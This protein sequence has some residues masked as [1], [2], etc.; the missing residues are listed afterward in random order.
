MKPIL[1][2]FCPTTTVFID[3]NSSMLMDLI[4]ALNLEN[5]PHL[6]FVQPQEGLSFINQDTYRQEF[7]ER[8]IIEDESQE[9]DGV[10]FSPQCFVPELQSPSRYHQISVLVVDYEMPGMTGLDL[11]KQ[12]QNPYVKTILLTGVADESIAIDAFNAG[13]I[14]T[15]IR[16]HNPNFL[17]LLRQA[18]QTNQQAYFQ[19]LFHTPLETLKRRP[20][21]TALGD[22]AFIDYFNGLVTKHHIQEYYL[23]EGTG[24]FLMI[25]RKKKLH[26]LI[27]LSDEMIKV[28]LT[29][30]MMDTLTPGKEGAI[31]NKELIPCYQNPFTK[32]YFETDNLENY[33]HK[34]TLLKGDH[35]PFYTVFGEGLIQVTPKDIVFWDDVKESR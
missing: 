4:P 20:G 33:L 1:P 30:A 9:G 17:D 5:H 2:C 3:D 10:S 28:Y 8:M 23:M 22:S 27:T 6:T 31:E 19:E 11:C 24:S 16:K 32:E 13:L 34:P 18:I 15:Y 12:I 29:W 25:D 14:S 7:V 21:Q 26:S 35:R